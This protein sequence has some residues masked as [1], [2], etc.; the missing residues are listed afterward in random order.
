MTRGI[1]ELTHYGVKGM[2]WGVRR[3]RNK[4]GSL[5]PAGKAKRA[6]SSTRGSRSDRLKTRLKTPSKID[7][8]KADFQEKH[9]GRTRASRYAGIGTGLAAALVGGDAIVRAVARSGNASLVSPAFG[10]LVNAGLYTAGYVVTTKAAD[11]AFK[12]LEAKQKG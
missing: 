9:A 6:K 1:N 12:K 7:R 3:Y 5:T 10:A 8:A 4:D 2:K 11:A